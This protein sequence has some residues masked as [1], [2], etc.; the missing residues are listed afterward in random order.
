M[1]Y[2]N[3][4]HYETSCNFS[5]PKRCNRKIFGRLIFKG[6]QQYMFNHNNQKNVFYITSE[7]NN[8]GVKFVW[9][10]F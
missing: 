10:F 4:V 8:M 1:R 6:R 9:N 7:S 2:F 3:S 5:V